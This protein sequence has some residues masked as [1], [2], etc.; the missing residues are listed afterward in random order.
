LSSGGSGRLVV[1]CCLA[2]STFISTWICI[3]LFYFYLFFQGDEKVK[4]VLLN[5]TN[6]DETR[7]VCLAVLGV[8][9]EEKQYL[10]EL[11]KILTEG[12]TLNY[13]VVEYLKDNADKS[14]QVAKLLELNQEIHMKKEQEKNS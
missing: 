4:E 9:T 10:D 3:D 13:T 12:N 5:Q 2:L 11:E 7:E 6:N 1:E 8:C 14:Q